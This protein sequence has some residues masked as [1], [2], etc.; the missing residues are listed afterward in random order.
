MHALDLARDAI[1]PLTVAQIKL[2]NIP[3]N[4]DQILE[5]AMDILGPKLGMTKKSL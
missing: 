4:L 1:Q 5:E 2:H 3:N